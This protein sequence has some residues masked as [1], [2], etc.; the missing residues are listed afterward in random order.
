MIDGN[1]N[2][3]ENQ[4]VF[5]NPRAPFFD[6][7]AA[8]V[9][10]IKRKR[11]EDEAMGIIGGGGG[12][13]AQGLM[14]YNEFIDATEMTGGMSFFW[15]DLFGS[16]S[17]VREEGIWLSNRLITANLAQWIVAVGVVPSLFFIFYRI[18]DTDEEFEST[19]AESEIDEME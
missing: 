8:L 11:L 1:G 6:R 9:G 18:N 5:R 4:E 7:M 16:R 17:F 13:Q 15:R 10:A 2:V 19:Q 3:L 14:H 12:F